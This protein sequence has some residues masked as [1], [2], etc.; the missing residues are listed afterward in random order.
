[1]AR[2]LVLEGPR[3]LRLRDADVP[4]REPQD[5]R[6]R[7]LLSSISHGTGLNLYRGSFPSIRPWTAP[8]QK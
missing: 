5:I 7:A 1:M 8:T 3:R 2:A 6:V 4:T